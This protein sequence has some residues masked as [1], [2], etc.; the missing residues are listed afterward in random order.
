MSG[1]YAAF[2]GGRRYDTGTA[3]NGTI[4]TAAA[5]AE[6]GNQDV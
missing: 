3:S 4:E 6:H 1:I 5:K 2:R